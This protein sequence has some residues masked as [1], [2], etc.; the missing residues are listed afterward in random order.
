M[1]CFCGF[2]A[3]GPLERALCLLREAK[4]N[5]VATEPLI[6]Y[7]DSLFKLIDSLVEDT[8]R[9][10][11][12][13]CRFNWNA[14]MPDEP[15][16]VKGIGSW[17]PPRSS[18]HFRHYPPPC[19]SP[20]T[21]DTGQLCSSLAHLAPALYLSFHF[22][23]SLRYLSTHQAAGRQEEE[24]QEVSATLRLCFSSD[25]ASAGL[26]SVY[27]LSG[28]RA[29]YGLDWVLLVNSCRFLCSSLPPSV[30][31][32]V[33]LRRLIQLICV[34][35]ELSTA[36]PKYNILDYTTYP[37]LVVKVEQDLLF[38][39]TSRFAPE[40]LLGCRR[41]TNRLHS[42]LE[43]AVPQEVIDTF[44]AG[45]KY[46]SP[47]A[48][49]KS[50]V[51][52]SWSE[53][54]ER[55]MK[56][57][58]GG[59][60]DYESDRE[61]NDEDPFFTIPI[62]FKLTGFVEPFEGKWDESIVR[63]LQA[64]WTELNSLLSNVPNLDRNGRS[65]DVESKNALEWCFNEN[66]LIKPTDKN[67]GT[68]LVS[69]VWY[70]EKVSSFLLSNKG[71]ALIC[72]EEARTLVRTTVN[73]VR[74]LCCNN[75]TTQAFLSG[76]LS[77]F[78]GSRL[79][80]PRVVDDVVMEDDW[81]SLIIAIP[82]FNGLP[83]I[84]KSPWGIRPVVPCHSVVQ[85]PVSEFLSKILKT[86]LADH[87]QILTSTKELV[88]ELEFACRDKLAN[89]SPLQW[90]TNVFICTADI[91][92]FYTNVPIKDCDLKLRDL[93]SHKF[94]RDR[95]GRVKADYIRELFLIQQNNLIFRAQ[96]N[97][98][99][100]YV[101]QT[102]GLAMGMPA[103]PDIAN[104]YAAWY[105]RR[106]PAAF[107]DR[108][109]LFKR[110]IDDII[111]VVRADSLDQCEQILRNYSIPGLKLNWEISETNAVFLDLDI[112]RSPSSRDHRLRYRPYRKP[113]NNFERL[114][115]CTGH[116]LQLLRGAFKSEVHRF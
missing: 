49:K 37:D 41:F 74:D 36:T 105:E 31:L 114:P 55:A 104:L 11:G 95:T 21:S 19:S 66:V 108:M 24:W 112:W 62:P 60:H 46:L 90:R 4:G 20:P 93:V 42:N 79:P 71:Y 106:L 102:D 109:L 86:L 18:L 82:V 44:S 50:L 7:I 101:K 52:V 87:L 85:G 64:G 65:F 110:Y 29:M 8:T 80:R 111:C 81:E 107:R 26:M 53:Y 12:C 28:F 48:M 51:K 16:R 58:A 9:P 2:F 113:L 39:V 68:A 94:G 57:W 72:E 27:G 13:P 56:S 92:G 10:P 116:A 97:G 43:V 54:C 70:E 84:H 78:L 30:L 63:I 99:W 96:I 38:M 89:L 88:H 75:S 5:L 76:N 98:S 17:T 14:I 61:N 1:A 67:L 100:E 40:W 59:Y 33:R 73:A 103:A 115:W 77:Q 45:L 6:C 83:K 22:S 15:T 23:G 91:K 47:I 69:K 3:H 25:S 34:F 32:D 35:V